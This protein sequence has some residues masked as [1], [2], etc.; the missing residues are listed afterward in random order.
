MFCA[1]SVVYAQGNPKA[2]P[3]A[4]V[5][6]EKLP[7]LGKAPVIVELFSSQACV[8]CPKADQLFADLI[9]QENVI[10]L[11]CHVDYFDVGTGS[12]AHD[13]CTERQTWYME[14][15]F[16]GPN[17]TPQMVINGAVDVVGYKFNDVVKAL[18]KAAYSEVLPLTISETTAAGTYKITM[19]QKPEPLGEYRLWLALYDKPHDV[20]IAEGRNKGHKAAYYNIVS[21]LGSTDKL[22]G[23]IYVTPPMKD[24]HKGFVVILQNMKTGKIYA[25]GRHKRA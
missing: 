22:A 5:E 7:I 10:G 2:M 3:V 17:F 12:L 19:A 23:D 21:Q 8:F 13:F 4:P 15:L 24:Q 11:A 25:V 9:Q 14:K 20:T 1:G 16:A 6:A 18:Q